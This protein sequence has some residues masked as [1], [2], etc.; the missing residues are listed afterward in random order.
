[1]ALICGSIQTRTWDG[2]DGQKR[3]ATEVIANEVNFVGSKKDNP[4]SQ[5]NASSDF[6]EATKPATTDEFM[7][8]DDDDSLP[9]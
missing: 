3:Y 6:A 4:S 9:F 7:P 1:M 2:Q 8:L 5:E